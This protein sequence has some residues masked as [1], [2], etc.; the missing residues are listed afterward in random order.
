MYQQFFR[1]IYQ[2]SSA[3]RGALEKGISPKRSQ[4]RRSFAFETTTRLEVLARLASASL[5]GSFRQTVAEWA[6]LMADR[7]NAISGN[8][9]LRPKAAILSQRR[10]S[11][12][13]G[14]RQVQCRGFLRTAVR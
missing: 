1:N 5:R 4:F 14:I 6:R 11:S 12:S 8:G 7:E 2:L 9:S 10:C 3:L 13:H